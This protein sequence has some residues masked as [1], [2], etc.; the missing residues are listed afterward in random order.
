MNRRHPSIRSIDDYIKAAPD[1]VQGALERLRATIRS[2]APGAVEKISYQMP[3]FFLSGNL[4][5][6]A[7]FKNHIGFYPTSSGIAAFKKELAAYETSKG[8][9]RFS[10]DKPLPLK[11][12]RRIVEFRVA[13]NTKKGLGRLRMGR[14]Q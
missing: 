14:P 2:A 13:E 4:V 12:I 6:F 3:A 10:L 11:L 9:V 8:T 7:A 5:Y 1:E